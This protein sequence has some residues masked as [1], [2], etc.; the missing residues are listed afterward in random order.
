MLA[1]GAVAALVVGKCL[2]QDNAI[3]RVMAAAP[4]R[5][6]GRV[7]YSFYLLHWMI[8]VLV[9]RGVAGATPLVAAAA[10]FGGGFALS[11]IAAT[12]SW[13]IAEQPYFRW[14]KAR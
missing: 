9:A 7:S 3:A 11:A 4:L 6:L 2:A 5:A 1:F 12:I 8:V 14:A 10:I 13:R